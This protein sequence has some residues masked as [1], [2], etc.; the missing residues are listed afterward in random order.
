M[1]VIMLIF[2]FV[3]VFTVLAILVWCV[4]DDDGS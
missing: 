1:N 2:M 3:Y 4:W